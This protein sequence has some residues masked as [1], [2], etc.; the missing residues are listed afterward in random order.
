[1][2]T[3]GCEI[4]AH[5]RDV[6]LRQPPFGGEHERH[7]EV[8]RRESLAQIGGQAGIVITRGEINVGAGALARGVDVA[9]HNM[10]ITP[11]A[12]DP[13]ENTDRHVA[14]PSAP[15]LPRIPH[16]LPLWLLLA[17][18][19]IFLHPPMPLYSTR[20]LTVAW[21]MWHLGEWLLPHQNGVPYSHKAPLLYWL[22]HAGWAL[23]G[24]NDV[25]PRLLEIALSLLNLALLARLAR[26]L[27]PRRPEI[28]RTAP[29]VLAGSLFYFLFA[30][31]IMFDLLVMAAALALFVAATRRSGATAA[32]SFPGI[33]LALALG[34]LAK[35]PVILLHVAFPLLLA[36]YWLEPARTAPRWWYG[37]LALAVIAALAL[38]ALWVV[39]VAVTGGTA[40]REEL[41]LTQTAGRVIDAFDHARPFWWYFA[42][43]PILLFPWFFWSGTWRALALAR[44]SHEPGHRFVLL[45]LLPT[46]AA[47]CLVSA[48]Q[49]YYLLPLLGAFALWLAEACATREQALG[50]VASTRSLVLVFVGLGAALIALPF[51]VARLDHPSLF[52]REMSAGSSVALT[53]AIVLAMGGMVAVGW[54]ADGDSSA[55]RLPLIGATSLIAAAALHAWFSLTASNRYDLRPA[56]AVLSEAAAAGRPIANRGVYEGQFHFLARLTRPLAE[57]DYHTGAAWARAHPDGVVVEY[58]AVPEANPSTQ[59]LHRQPFRGEVLELWRAADWLAQ[60]RYCD[61]SGS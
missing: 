49:A 46:F 54:R 57:I 34:L 51:I 17:G 4:G 48:K 15:T 60:C 31:Q 28:A 27:F 56:A 30:L 41:L 36:P 43:L 22:I 59:A 37:R 14:A 23:G 45:W 3:E 20:T 40:Y 21:E 12:Y 39:P 50:R 53:G 58:V 8:E 42:V 6:R 19:S 7:H 32:P 47:F 38:F 52:L 9:F 10:R 26:Q 24:V 18:V 25:W 11:D 44:H 16:W 29:W 61:R 5:D 1:M 35:G 13:Y 2:I 55:R 33:A